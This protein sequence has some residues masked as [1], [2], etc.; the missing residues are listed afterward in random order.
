MIKNNPNNIFYR[1]KMAFAKMKVYKLSIHDF[2]FQVKLGEFRD[3]TYNLYS[4]T[5][6]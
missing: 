4:I 3:G 1:R 2:E 5:E 6:P